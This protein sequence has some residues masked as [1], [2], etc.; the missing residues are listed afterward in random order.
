MIDPSDDPEE[1]SQTCHTCVPD[2]KKRAKTKRLITD[3]RKNST[4]SFTLFENIFY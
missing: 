3:S 1:R 4:F 2:I